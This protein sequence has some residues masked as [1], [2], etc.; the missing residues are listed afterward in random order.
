MRI[1]QARLGGEGTEESFDAMQ[2]TLHQVPG[3]L[4][5]CLTASLLITLLGLA[6]FHLV[7]MS[8]KS[9]AG[10]FA[11]LDAAE[12]AVRH[13]LERHVDQLASQIGERNLWRYPALKAAAD[14]IRDTFLELG[15]QPLALPYVSQGKIVENLVA[16]KLGT[17]LA[18]EILVVGAHYDT[19]LGSP[20]AND[21]GSGVAAL[22]ELARLLKDK[23][24]HRTIRFVAFANEEA[25]FSYS[26]EMGS[27][28][29]ATQAHDKGERITAMLSLETIGY[30]ADAP[31][32]QH[33]PFPFSYFYPDTANFIGFVGNL[34][35]RSLVRRSLS[36]FRHTTPFPAEGVAAPSQ[37]TGIGWSDH[38]SFWQAGY[39]AIMITD[40]AL[41]RYPHYH[42]STD[43]PDKV[44]YPRTARVV[45]GISRVLEALADD[46]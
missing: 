2:L 12:T 17:R 11:P 13:R 37:I 22:L 44:D 20:G 4:W 32:S 3:W 38:W 18:E 34:S 30:Y 21:N 5:F 43:T 27:L 10:P 28:V 19:V 36:A 31:G 15:Y 39:P 8:G 26:D 7:V 46:P 33:Y 6:T 35:S 41:F 24:L 42:A 16:E 9:Y 23:P 25:P 29:Y 14:Y 1:E 40:T 45:I